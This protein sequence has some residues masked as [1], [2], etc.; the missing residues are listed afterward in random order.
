MSDYPD[1]RIHVAERLKMTACAVAAVLS[2]SLGAGSAALAQGATP[3]ST[4]T[5]ACNAPALPP[6]SPTAMGGS[7]TP[8]SDNMGAMATPAASPEATPAP[9]GTPADAATGAAII[10]AAQNIANCGNFGNYEGLVALLTSNFLKTTLNVTNP[11]NAVEGLKQQGMSFGDFK[12]MNPITY[13]DG[14]AGVDVSYMQTKYQ[15]AAERWTLIKDG[16]YWKLDSLQ[17]LTPM[18]GLD[19]SVLG[20]DLAGAKDPKSGKY[21]YSITPATYDAK[22]N[23]SHFTAAQA[24]DLHARNLGANAEEH[25]VVV[26]KLPAGADPAG[27]FNG[28]IKASDVEFIGQVTVPAGTEKDLFL[29]GL[30]AGE[31][32]LACFIP[33][34]DGVPHAMEGMITKLVI[35]PAS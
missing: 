24:L 33:G 23:E 34:P 30:P 2:L 28:T 25:E 7:S 14:S 29:I 35:D 22:T 1:K 15:L 20:V 12:A 16:D 27:L 18:T 26:L 13:A 6:G 21:V 8:S 11:Y 9:A 5:A 19:T 10:G 3:A 32:T 17:T 31:Y 4:P